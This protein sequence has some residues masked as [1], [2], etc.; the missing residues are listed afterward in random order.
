[1][2]TI[3]KVR[4]TTNVAH[5]DRM[6]KTGEVYLI[7]QP[8]VNE[9]GSTYTLTPDMADKL[10]NVL[11]IAFAEVFDVFEEPEV[12]ES[13]PTPAETP[14]PQSPGPVVAP[15][16]TP[17]P[18]LTTTSGTEV[19]TPPS[20]GTTPIPPEQAVI[21]SDSTVTKIPPIVPPN[22][23]V[24]GVTISTGVTPVEIAPPVSETPPVIPPMQQG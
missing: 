22:I 10:L 14:S 3:T 18:V 5:G 6:L 1:M 17:S 24:E 4:M 8:T 23:T 16:P 7:G 21:I 15:T 2:A 20:V 9:D 11:P 19:V 12:E 13:Q